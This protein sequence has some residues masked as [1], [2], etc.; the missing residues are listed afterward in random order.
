MLKKELGRLKRH[1][2][3]RK[4]MLG[5]PERPRL[6]VHRSAQHLYVQ[7][8]DDIQGHTLLGLSTAD[9]E[10][11]AVKPKNGK[12]TAAEK[13]GEIFGS[14]LKTK[15]IQQIAFDR[16]GYLYHGRVKALAEALRKAGIAF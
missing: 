2:R 6:S 10:F 15:G 8:I 3:I 1:G 11:Q 12:V 16:G 14:K 13:L 7:V 9:K 4:K 5:T